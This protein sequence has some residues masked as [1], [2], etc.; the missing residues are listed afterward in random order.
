MGEASLMLWRLHILGAIKQLEALTQEEMCF[1]QLD[2][3]AAIIPSRLFVFASI[4]LIIGFELNLF[5]LITQL[6]LDFPLH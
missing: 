3:Q 1:T 6:Y 2:F 5:K 4:L